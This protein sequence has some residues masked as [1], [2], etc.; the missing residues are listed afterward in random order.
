MTKKRTG[1]QWQ[2][3]FQFSRI[4]NFSPTSNHHHSR[5]AVDF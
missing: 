3:G 1:L 4:S 2:A 5:G